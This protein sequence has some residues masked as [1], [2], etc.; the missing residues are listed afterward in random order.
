MAFAARNAGWRWFARR[1]RATQPLNWLATRAVRSAARACGSTPSWAVEHLH[2]V[3]RVAALLPNGHAL[4]LWSRGDDWVCNQLFWRGWR[5][6]EVETAPVFFRLAQVSACVLD[7]GAYV[8]YFALLAARANPTSR[9][10]AVEALPIVYQ[11]LR[12]NVLLNHLA[13]RVDCVLTAAGAQVGTAQFYYQGVGLP[14][15]SSLSW[16]FMRGTGDLVASDVPVVRVDELL[17]E[18]R[19]ERLDLAKIDTESTE[20]DVL[21]GMLETLR[22]DRPWIICEVLLGRGAE[23][24]L[25]DLLRSL[26]Y[27]F[28]LL[29]P[30]GP[31]AREFI[32]GHPTCLNYLFAGRTDALHLLG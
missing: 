29:T 20:P 11:R 16:E 12:R 7:V 19:I 8:G 2:P 6:H 17:R 28:Y 1:V 25:N 5:A 30:E 10:V 3:G 26:D 14:S 24:A 22:R 27:R 31:V 9:V 4:H 21:V 15:S 13:D 32:E 23:S 18:R